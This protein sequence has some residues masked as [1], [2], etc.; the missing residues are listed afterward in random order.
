MWLPD[1]HSGT[2][3]TRRLLRCV[4][5]MRLRLCNLFY[6]IYCVLELYSLCSMPYCEV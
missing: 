1:I 6:T 5:V 4:L 3:M 2:P